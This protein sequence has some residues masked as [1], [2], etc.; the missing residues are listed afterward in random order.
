VAT[1][2][3]RISR[4]LAQQ[5]IERLQ[6]ERLPVEGGLFVQTWK[7]CEGDNVLGTATY[8]ALTDEPDSFSAMHRLPADEI[9]HFYLGDGVELLLL[10]PG[11]KSSTPILGHDIINGQ[12]PQLVVPAGTWMGARL[13]PGGVFGLFGNTMAPGFESNCYVGGD[14]DELCAGW[15]DVADRIEALIHPGGG[16]VMPEGF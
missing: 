3:D 11:G 1:V 10:H 15:P 8:A 7:S 2:T 9:W 4:D 13:A 12:S 5:I 14:V 6:L 16:L